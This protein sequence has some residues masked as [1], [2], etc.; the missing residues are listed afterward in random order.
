MDA[1]TRSS[2]SKALH[3]VIDDDQRTLREALADYSPQELR[4]L[5]RWACKLSDVC[6]ELEKERR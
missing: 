4:E 6:D 2:E 1:W 5:S 3:A